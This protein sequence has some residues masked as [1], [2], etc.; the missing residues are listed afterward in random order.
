MCSCS[1]S[2]RRRRRRRRRSGLKKF[3]KMSPADYT[4]DRRTGVPAGKVAQP[5]QSGGQE[6]G[7]VAS[8]AD[9][10]AK[11]VTHPLSLSLSLLI[12]CTS[13]RPASRLSCSH[14]SPLL[15]SEP[16][17][18]MSDPLCELVSACEHRSQPHKVKGF[19]NFAHSVKI[20]IAPRT[21]VWGIKKLFH[22][23]WNARELLA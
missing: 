18:L 11:Y 22:P 5:G 16:R 15:S 6:E 3:A 9:R 7:C 19:E 10:R 2:K 23:H 1:L 4:A 21:R 13:C 20:I 12:Q 14:F 17:L 8:G